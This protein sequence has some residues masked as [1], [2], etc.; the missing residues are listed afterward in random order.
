ML[1]ENDSV[2][3]EVDHLRLFSVFVHVHLD[4]KLVVFILE[5]V[6]DLKGLMQALDLP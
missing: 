5:V 3:F 1:I 2:D 4:R 6:R